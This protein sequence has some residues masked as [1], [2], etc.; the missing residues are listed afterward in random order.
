MSYKATNWAY[1]LPLTGSQKFVLVA[2]ADMADEANT[3]YPG[4]QR[5][6]E[7]TGFSEATVR[8]ALKALEESG[9]LSREARH[10]AY[11]YRTSDRY[12]LNVGSL[13]V[14]VPARQD[15]HRSESPSLP[16]TVHVP[17]GH[18]DGAVE[19]LEEPSDEP[20]E[21]SRSF[22]DE[23][24]EW[25]GLYPRKQAKVDA[26]KAFKTARKTEPFELLLSGL[27]T[28][29]LMNAGQ[30]KNFLKLPAG[31]L[32]DGRWADEAVEASTGTSKPPRKGEE[33]EC[34]VH[35]GYPVLNPQQEW[36]HWKCVRCR[37]EQTEG[38]GDF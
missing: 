19:P 24:A 25:W 35:K 7:M 29:L 22:E 16:V 20:I 30:P 1:E 23:F 12:R 8:R 2:L 34:P 11:G 5:I 31:W 13:P 14:T 10:G 33:Q 3:C 15:A 28:Y 21:I 4:Q 26:F 38:L 17:T 9:L 36:P 32:R 37:R 18:G 27:R 6:A